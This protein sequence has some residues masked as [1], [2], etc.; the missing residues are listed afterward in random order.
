MQFTPIYNIK[1][2]LL[3]GCLSYNKRTEAAGI[4]EIALHDFRRTSAGNILDAG[5]DIV[6][7][8]QLPVDE[9]ASPT[10]SV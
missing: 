1:S 5:I 10:R 3:H 2:G 8:Q 9:P 4:P 6:A 7:V